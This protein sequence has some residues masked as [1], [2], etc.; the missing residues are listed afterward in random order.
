M[1]ACTYENT[2]WFTLAGLVCR[3]RVLAVPDGDTV[4]V[5]LVL[6][7]ADAPAKFSCR[8]ARIDCPE[9]A[10]GGPGLAARAHLLRLLGAADH[11]AAEAVQTGRNDDRAYWA[12]HPTYVEMRCGGFDK[13]GR[14]LGELVSAH[15][16]FADTINEAM[17][18][19][20]HAVA[21]TV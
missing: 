21:Y 4:T 5:A 19:A 13:Y 2:D 3:A 15:V 12:A 7:N 17:V 11:P 1:D 16:P 10:T 14:L 9:L 20:G 18:L 6:P 8:L